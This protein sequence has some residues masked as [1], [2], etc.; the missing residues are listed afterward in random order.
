MIRF[1]KLANIQKQSAFIV[2]YN[3]AYS[4]NETAE[5]YIDYGSMLTMQTALKRLLDDVY[6][7]LTVPVKAKKTINL[8][9]LGV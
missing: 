5:A 2:N 9:H 8:G 4:E 6:S 3:D 1:A 7:D